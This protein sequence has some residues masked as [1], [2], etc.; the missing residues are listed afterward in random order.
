MLVQYYAVRQKADVG[1][2]FTEIER[3]EKK[4]IRSMRIK[5]VNVTDIVATTYQFSFSLN[6]TFHY[7]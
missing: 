4:N 6:Q 5:Y 1:I 3:K 7:N 2:V